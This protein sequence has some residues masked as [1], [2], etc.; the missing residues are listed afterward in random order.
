MLTLFNALSRKIRERGKTIKQKLEPEELLKQFE[1]HCIDLI[2]AKTT[3]N[4]HAL[5]DATILCGEFVDLLAVTINTMKSKAS[6]EPHS[7]D[8]IG[9]VISYLTKLEIELQGIR[10]HIAETVDKGLLETVRANKHELERHRKRIQFELE[11]Q[12]ILERIEK[13]QRLPE[14]SRIKNYRD[15]INDIKTLIDKCS[16]MP[17]MSDFSLVFEDMLQMQLAEDLRLRERHEKPITRQDGAGLVEQITIYM[18]QDPDTSTTYF[19]SPSADGTP[20][21]TTVGQALVTARQRLQRSWHDTIK[22][23]TEDIKRLVAEGKIEVADR[24]FRDRTGQIPGWNENIGVNRSDQINRMMKDAENEI[25]TGQQRLNET[26][27]KLADIKR[28]VEQFQLLLAFTRLLESKTDLNLYLP[29]EYDANYNII[30]HSFTSHY[31]T[32]KSWTIDAIVDQNWPMVEHIKQLLLDYDKLRMHFPLND[33]YSNQVKTCRSMISHCEALSNDTNDDHSKVESLTTLKVL[34]SEGQFM[35]CGWLRQTELQL[36]LSLKTDEIKNKFLHFQ[37]TGQ[38]HHDDVETLLE[39]LKNNQYTQYNDLRPGLECWRLYYIAEH[40]LN[41]SN[42]DLDKVQTLLDDIAGYQFNNPVMSQNLQK[43]TKDLRGYV[44][45]CTTRIDKIISDSSNLINHDQTIT[46]F[47]D[48]TPTIHLYNSIHK[49][50]QS[51]STRKS[52]LQGF[53][54]T[55]AVEIQH[56]MRQLLDTGPESTIFD[57][58]QSKYFNDIQR[59]CQYADISDLHILKSNYYDALGIQMSGNVEK[60]AQEIGFKLHLEYTHLGQH[61]DYIPR[62]SYASMFIKRFYDAIR[63]QYILNQIMFIFESNERYTD[64]EY[65]KVT[66]YWSSLDPRL[67]RRIK[68]HYGEYIV[69]R[70]NDKLDV[71]LQ[72][73]FQDF[74]DLISSYDAIASYRDKYRSWITQ[75]SDQRIL[76]YDF[77][78]SFCSNITEIAKHRNLTTVVE[79]YEKTYS[80]FRNTYHSLQ[81]PQDHGILSKLIKF[82]NVHAP[83]L[84]IYSNIDPKSSQL[85][86]KAAEFIIRWYIRDDIQK[87]DLRENRDDHKFGDIIIQLTDSL[88]QHLRCING[89]SLSPYKSDEYSDADLTVHQLEAFVNHIESDIRAFHL[90]KQF[91]SNRGL[92]GKTVEPQQRVEQL[93]KPLNSLQK[94]VE[95]CRRLKLTIARKQ[96]VTAPDF[97]DKLREYLPNMGAYISKI[98]ATLIDLS[99]MRDLSNYITVFSEEI[100]VFTQQSWLLPNATQLN[101]HIMRLEAYTAKYAELSPRLASLSTNHVHVEWYGGSLDQCRDQLRSI[102]IY[103]DHII[104]TKRQLDSSYDALKH[105]RMDQ[106]TF[107]STIQHII[108]ADIPAAFRTTTSYESWSNFLQAL[109]NAIKASHL[110]GAQFPDH[111]I[112]FIKRST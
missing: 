64:S 63:Q 104:T 46:S 112:D 22:R 100:D 68:K 58:I 82:W 107:C 71:I 9:Q 88:E 38:L 10:T 48:L 83:K 96:R 37:K 17:D 60:D 47:S 59:I 90:L 41:R 39:A 84:I 42:A 5:A 44:N 103:L 105:G 109:S 43:L 93:L 73:T 53:M 61:M 26:Q 7:L 15:I 1:L 35:T 92:P 54:G 101:D 111:W 29:G 49:E 89:D 6:L 77:I 97:T 99:S 70:F 69:D 51:P 32:I 36:L 4:H 86:H 16:Q 50:L 19:G 45:R 11:K 62:Q 81:D 28:L 57:I 75:N 56:H 34:I 30:K 21:Q 98:D 67:K 87:H 14:P 94:A 27:S 40:E 66:T 79:C 18:S 85:E 110:D 12:S 108:N 3:S 24:E 72:N 78:A 8:R 13:N 106:E 95:V 25:K 91:F 65:H 80:N 33:D 74:G 23:I 55:F 31:S 2:Q 102:A 20:T 76:L 52:E